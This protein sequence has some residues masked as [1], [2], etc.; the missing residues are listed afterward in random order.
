MARDTYKVKGG[1]NY[2]A[3]AK[4]FG[5]TAAQLGRLNNFAD[6]Q[7]GMVIKINVPKG[8]PRGFGRAAQA[9]FGLSPTGVPTGQQ[10]T[11]TTPEPT[12]SEA[13]QP[14]PT[15][16]ALG[17]NPQAIQGGAVTPPPQDLLNT[18]IT[19]ARP[20]IGQDIVSQSINQDVGLTPPGIEG[21]NIFAGAEGPPAPQFEPPS[22]L[23][24]MGAGATVGTDALSQAAQG[25]ATGVPVP[26]EGVEG[27][28]AQPPPITADQA[29]AAA[30]Q[31][32]AD[33]PKK[34]I[35][36]TAAKTQQK[37]L[38][39]EQSGNRDQLPETMAST[40][41]A[42]IMN[43]FILSSG[44]PAQS[45][46]EFMDILDYTKYEPGVWVKNNPINSSAGYS[47]GYAGLAGPR[48]SFARGTASRRNTSGSSY[49]AFSN[50]VLYN[51]NIDFD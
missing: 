29:Y 19:T 37:L 27:L 32:F 1:D 22:F 46:E 18:P 10:T 39:Y 11:P 50:S 44:L 24:T 51:W 3:L 7:S 38:L 16:S 17:Y 49:G 42:M 26:G 8:S 4:R 2:F 6:L 43:E 41:A 5:V 35:A 14:L 36:Y 21:A 31:S 34:Q 23:E 9:A 45:V 20:N 30:W 40:T 15:E 25:A 12:P 28:F 13:A 47:T 33:S 48:Y